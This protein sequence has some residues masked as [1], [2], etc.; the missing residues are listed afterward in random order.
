M[1]A[2][3]KLPTAV[4]NT[5]WL[6]SPG[7]DRGRLSGLFESRGVWAIAD[8]GIVSLGNFLTT[9]IL[10]RSLSP[11]AY[12]VWSII[13]GFVIFLNVLHASLII[14][15]LSVVV[16]TRDEDE[17]GHIIASALALT[18]A[19][20][21][22]LGLVLV[23]ASWLIGEPKVGLWAC[24]ALFFWQLQE[25]TRRALM[26]RLS[27]R[28]ALLTDAVSYLGQA[29]LIWF[30]ANRGTLSSESCFVVIAL[31]CVVAGIAQALMLHLR[32]ISAQGCRT[33]IGRFWEL[34]HWVLWANLATNLSL[35]VVPWVLF[36]ARGASDVAAFQAI[37]NLLGFSHP[38]MLS[39]G[40]IIV[41]AA[42]RA[43]V[44]EGLRAAQRVAVVHAT[45]GGLLLLPYFAA[46]L[47]FPRQLLGLFY[48]SRSPYLALTGP[49]R[50]FALV[51]A[52]YYLTL[53]VKFLLNA[54][55]ENRAQFT[56]ELVSSLIL[57]S[58]IV[59]LVIFY[60]LLGAIVATGAWFSARLACNA[61][62]M[63][64]M[65]W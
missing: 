19:L 8:Q 18:A 51:Y 55:E 60:G 23:S 61:V 39:L 47:L 35:Q 43:R 53:A 62:V 12:G 20:A 29:G 40:N 31:T 2:K 7:R 37:S 65:R 34:G 64:Q 21:L 42:A 36:L 26:A 14:Y 13:F 6:K 10:A 25:T 48:G 54:L 11:E 52:I 27:F 17:T 9:I 58:T 44:R 49:L 38:I 56:A 59:P 45:Q 32:A 22:P 57:V 15:P 30:L 63:R 4:A 16:A 1:E 50:L 3:T 41:P 5:G 33:L 46:L 28:K 24:V